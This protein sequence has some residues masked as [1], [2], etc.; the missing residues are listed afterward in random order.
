M[1]GSGVEWAGEEGLRGLVL[2][3]EDELVEEQEEN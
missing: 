3:D 1:V 2:E